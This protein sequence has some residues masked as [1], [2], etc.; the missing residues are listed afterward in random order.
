MCVAVFCLLCNALLSGGRSQTV[1]VART[2]QW[3]GH[4]RGQ[5]YDMVISGTNAYLIGSGAALGVVNI[6]NPTNLAWV[7]G[8]GFGN[9]S[10]GVAVDGTNAFLTG[11]FLVNNVA[12]FV[13]N[14][15]NIA[16]PSSISLTGQ[17]II[18]GFPLGV[19]VSGNHAFVANNGLQV[20]DISNAASPV[21]VGTY[22]TGINAAPDVVVQ[23]NY[24]YLANAANGLQ[25]F[26]VSNPANIVPVGGYITQASARDVAVSGAYAYVADA[27]G[28]FQILD[29]SDPANPVWVGGYVTSGGAYGVA[30]SGQ[31]A[32]VA[33]NDEGLHVFDISNPANPVLVG[34][35]DTVRYALRVA[36]AGNYAY[37]A[38]LDAGMQMIDVS[39]PTNLVQVGGFD[40]SG[41]AYDVATSGN[42]AYLADWNAGFRIIDFSNPTNPI[43]R[44]QYFTMASNRESWAVATSGNFAYLVGYQ[45]GA[46]F[47]NFVDVMNVSDPDNPVRV[48]EVNLGPS[49]VPE[50]IVVRSNY[51]Y[52]ALE[53]AGLKVV[54]VANPTNPVI[55][56][57]YSF[58]AGGS[59]YGI[60]LSGNRAY[61]AD[62]VGLRIFHMNTPT[63]FTQI[64]R[65]TNSSGFAARVAVQGNY[66]YLADGSTGLVVLN[67]SNPTNPI[68]V[69]MVDIGYAENIA[70]S[71]NYA[72]VTDDSYGVHVL[73]ITDPTNPACAGSYKTPG[74]AFAVAVSSNNYVCVADGFWGLQL[75]KPEV[76]PGYKLTVEKLGNNVQLHWSLR[77]TNYV[78]ETT[79]N[80]SPT[81]WQTVVTAPQNANGCYVLTVPATNP[82]A[83][84]RLRQF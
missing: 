35:I 32:Y 57:G 71:G 16:N 47:Y 44:G 77:A 59:A 52:V 66:A 49:G 50:D 54:N 42:F 23:G 25:I 34:T 21:I 39:N 8:Y 63:S 11:M 24:A 6:S 61:V 72:Y 2:G 48:R 83:F 68:P 26:D 38:D 74:N 56:G 4:P 69:A 51:A 78:L 31:Y 27:W 20:I 18:D 70:I 29:V 10:G 33:A 80:L 73:D 40:T 36:I 84:Y 12:S 45:D 41:S 7:G 60:A 75:L 76:L 81:N 43:Q 15:L 46:S 62:S 19:I 37:V 65:Y 28:G 53:D 17:T 13:I 82:A 79:A 9:G 14:E 67:V 55:A 64:A 3:P 5:V 1:E 30:L 22:I 58:A